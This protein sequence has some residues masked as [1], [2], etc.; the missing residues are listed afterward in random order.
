MQRCPAYSCYTSLT[1][2]H[3]RSYVR[4]GRPVT[5]Y[6]TVLRNRAIRIDCAGSDCQSTEPSS[7]QDGFGQES[8]H[9]S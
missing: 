3:W 9:C 2:E 6:L 1:I 8:P 7:S 5:G 4:A